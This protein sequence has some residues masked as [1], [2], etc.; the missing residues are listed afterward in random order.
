M[1]RGF[2]HLTVIGVVLSLGAAAPASRWRTAHAKPTRAAQTVSDDAPPAGLSH[3]DWAQIRESIAAS[4]YHASRIEKP[5]EEPSLVAPNRA[6]RYRTTFRPS[7]IEIASKPG[8][9]QEWRLMVSVA[10][11][12]NQ[13]NIRPLTSA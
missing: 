7:G 11:F 6:Q 13:G 9:G 5:G 12:G 4:S 2:S 10:G 8:P 3:G 1:H